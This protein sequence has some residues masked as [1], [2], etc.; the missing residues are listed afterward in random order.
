MLC[1]RVPRYAG[2]AIHTGLVNPSNLFLNRDEKIGD[3]CTSRESV[4]ADREKAALCVC[5]LHKTGVLTG[6]CYLGCVLTWVWLKSITVCW[7]YYVVIVIKEQSMW[8]FNFAF[9]SQT[10][11]LFSDVSVVIAIS[12]KRARCV[13]R[14]LS[15]APRPL[16]YLFCSHPINWDPAIV[17]GCTDQVRTEL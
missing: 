10:F 17:P 6:R 3:M 7:E 2:S 13:F 15:V 11:Y 16:F 4:K 5:D 12:W 14:I 1:V 8:H 9:G